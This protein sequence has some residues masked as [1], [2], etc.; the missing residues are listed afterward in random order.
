VLQRVQVSIVF[1]INQGYRLKGFRLKGLRLKGFRVKP[2][3]RLKGLRP[4]VGLFSLSGLFGSSG[5]LRSAKH[6]R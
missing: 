2:E 5:W 4:K 1:V 3:G 6:T